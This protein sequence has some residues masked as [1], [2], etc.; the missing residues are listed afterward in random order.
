VAFIWWPNGDY[1][2][3]Q[4]G[5]KGTLASGVSSFKDIGTGRPSLTV[6][7]EAELKGAPGKSSRLAATTDKPKQGQ[8]DAGSKQKEQAPA[9]ANPDD[10]SQQPEDQAQEPSQTA[11][12]Q[13]PQQTAPSGTQP[14]PADQQQAPSGTAPQAAPAPEP[15]PP[16]STTP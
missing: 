8:K 16:T 5:E 9:G 11:P 7:R 6:E 3:I 4:P 1:R 10:Q 15:A 12:E 14:P 2:P 13:Q